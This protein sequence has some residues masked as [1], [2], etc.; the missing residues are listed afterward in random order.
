MRLFS[1]IE[2]SDEVRDC[3]VDV[4]GRLKAAAPARWSPRDNLHLTL[5]FYGQW[6]DERLGELEASLSAIDQPQSVRIELRKLAFFSNERAPRVLVATVEP[7]APAEPKIDEFG[8]AYA[9]GKRKDS[10]ARVWIKPGS[11]KIAVNGREVER[12]FARPTLR[13]II[14]PQALRVIVPPLTS[15]YLNLTKNS[16]LATAIAYPDAPVPVE[17]N[18]WSVVKRLYQ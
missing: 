10:V 15:Q 2:L 3:L 16:S 11:G 17:P 13:L 12:Y 14:I 18:T 5:R 9:T 1:A 4:Q 6:P 8:R 7:V